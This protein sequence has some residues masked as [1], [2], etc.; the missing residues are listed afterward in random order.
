MTIN[1]KQRKELTDLVQLLRSIRGRHTELVT[2]M[3][4]SDTNIFPVIRQ[5][6]A[7]RS[8]AENIKSKQTRTAVIDSIESIIRELK[9][10]KQTPKNGLALFAGNVS[11]KE[12]NQDIKLWAIEPPKPLRVRTYRCDQVFVVEPLQEMLDV[13]EVYGLVVMD[14]KEA[15][16]G[17]LEGKQIKVLRHLTSNVPG[18][19][20]T[21][22]QS[23]ARF[24]RIRDG[25]AKDF[26]KRIAE[27]MKELF[28]DMPKLKGIL[29]GGPIPTK[30]DFLKEGELV[31]KLKNLIIAIKDIG[32][33][34]EHGLEILVESSEKEISQ[35]EMVLEK[36]LLTRFFEMLGKNKEKTVYG[37]EKTKHA[38]KRGAVELLLVSMK[39]PKEQVE[40]LE[41]LAIA[42]GTEMIII[43][44]DNQDG[45]QFFNLTKGIGGILRYQLE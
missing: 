18:K 16:M 40:E 10:Y 45:E 12:G 44:M 9:N 25:M 6:E 20:K 34:D 41:P 36:N 22:G 30:E 5:L 21:G 14:R 37:Y 38:L 15:T 33:T 3:I 13:D 27:N 31:T 7:E 42:S 43:S 29:I 24:E 8:T 32:E 19:Y 23:A 26:Y 11:E 39:V 2:V 35:Q 1:T 17:V 4:P 28:F